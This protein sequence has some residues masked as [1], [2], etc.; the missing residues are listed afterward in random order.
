MG[1][2]S[3]FGFAMVMHPHDADC[4]YIFPVES[5]EFRCALEIS[6]VLFWQDLREV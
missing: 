1:V 3:D 5:D 2:P 4:V 6:V